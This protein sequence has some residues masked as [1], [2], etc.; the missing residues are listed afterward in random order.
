M[1][2][3]MGDQQSIRNLS[4]YPSPSI[5]TM[6]AIA[7]TGFVASYCKH[8][9][10]SQRN[11]AFHGV[12]IKKQDQTYAIFMDSRE[13]EQLITYRINSFPDRMNKTINHTPKTNSSIFKWN[14]KIESLNDS[15]QT[16]E[17]LLNERQLFF[18]TDLDN[19]V[20]MLKRAIEQ[21]IIDESLI[22]QRVKELLAFRLPRAKETEKANK[23]QNY[24]RYE[25]YRKSIVC[26][27]RNF[28][29]LTDLSDIE[30]GLY[31]N[32]T[33]KQHNLIDFLKRYTDNVIPSHPSVLANAARMRYFIVAAQTMEEI[34]E[35]AITISEVDRAFDNQIV[36]FYTGPLSNAIFEDSLLQ[37]F[38]TLFLAEG[39]SNLIFDLQS[40]AL[41]GG[42]EIKA[43]THFPLSAQKT[44]FSSIAI[45][46]SRLGYAPGE[47]EGINEN[48]LLQIDAIM[49]EMQRLK[50]APGGQV[51][52]ARHGF[53]V[54]NK[55]FGKDS[56][57]KGEAVEPEN[58]YDLASVTKVIAT[59]PLMMKLYDEQAIGNNTRLG[60]ILPTAKNSNKAD[61]TIEEL[62]LHQAGLPAFIPFY[63]HALDSTTI[64]RPLYSKRFSKEYPIRVDNRLYMLAEARYKPTIFQ[65]HAD[66]MFSIPVADNMFMS[67]SFKDQMLQKI[68]NEPLRKK[69]FRYSDLSLYL[70][71]QV[72]EHHY[73][74]P[75]NILFDQYFAQPLGAKRLTFM[76]LE[77]FKAQEVMPTEN[78]Q[79]FRRQMLRG[80]VHDQGAAMMGG[81]A[82]HAGLFANSNDLAKMAQMLLNKGCYGGKQFITPHTVELFTRQQIETNRRGLGF[83]KPDADRTKTQPCSRLVS[84]SSYGHS[85]FT[86]TFVWI[87]P[88]KELIYIF[89]S[90]RVHP[91]AYN[92][93]LSNMGFRVRV[94]DVIYNA[95]T[96]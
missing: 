72:I 90:N 25:C 17:A 38:N 50:A 53:V 94:Q 16:L 62:L 8:L 34:R 29:F 68:Y 55:S 28:E 64:Q 93:K 20:A 95:L 78:D 14:T 18:A 22:E 91:N 26:L 39:P 84:Q 75:E 80:Y 86:G 13:K 82:G 37:Q 76:P 49:G 35:A 40:Q 21:K 58:L 59:T 6:Q 57:T 2:L 70:A 73:Q 52:V 66:S 1:L 79:S 81:V 7:D 83:D 65:S 12:C 45:Q 44:G 41:F 4:R 92:N 61:I 10:T 88:D 96:E 33:A 9:L 46:K 43:N 51:L 85:G 87:D 71:Q 32:Q 23:S 15:R 27:S 48:T 42:I 3:L 56:Y 67:S 11:S 63:L 24:W 19:H 77:R 47:N 5:Q 31:N 36:L 69:E 30:I 74:K 89:L 54:Y 60:E